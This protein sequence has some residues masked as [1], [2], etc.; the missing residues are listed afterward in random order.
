M[1]ILV[2]G[3]TS[4]LGEAIV[5]ALLRS[6]H[7]VHFTYCGNAKKA[8]ELCK[9]GS[10]IFAY[11]CDF[12]D[13]SSVED[14]CLTLGEMELDA[15]VNNAFTGHFLERQCHRNDPSI[16]QEMFQN[17]VIPT[18]QITH[19]AIVGFKKRHFGRIV[20]ILTSGLLGN[21]PVGSSA[22]VAAKAYLGQ[23]SRCWATEYIRSGI[24]ANTISPSFMRT[25]F[26]A[27]MD[28]RV[29]D[30][31]A[32]SHPLGRLLDCHDAA[33]TVEFLLTSPAD[34]NGVDIPVTAGLVMH[35]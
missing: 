9:E 21:P 6:G 34:V 8:E 22:Y 2:T 19:Q 1:N 33:R 28:E 24:T 25:N 29:A 18:L 4:G 11:H 7:S 12:R 32:S 26:T 17:N 23:M 5:T 14:F 15:L 27:E 10:T 35:S 30:A 16:Y 31:I 13:K 20:T 3:G